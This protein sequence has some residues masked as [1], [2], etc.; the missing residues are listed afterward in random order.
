MFDS[1][2]DEGL[3][4]NNKRTI[5]IKESMHVVFDET[6]PQRLEKKCLFMMMMMM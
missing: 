3:F 1:K 2:A 4:L 6:N 5:R